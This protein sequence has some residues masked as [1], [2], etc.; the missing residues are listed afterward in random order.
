MKHGRGRLTKKNIDEPHE[1]P[2][3]GAFEND[4]L[5]GLAVVGGK[6]AMYKEG[7][8]VQLK[9]HDKPEEKMRILYL[10]CMTAYIYCLPFILFFY[11]DYFSLVLV[12]PALILW[13]VF[14]L[15]YQYAACAILEFRGYL[16]NSLSLKQLFEDIRLA[17]ESPPVC[18]F[19]I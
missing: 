16:G 19:K 13:I 17:I 4:Q 1:E 6:T 3:F 8:A 11:W 9:N 15:A 10:L 12:I 5:N 7:L 18:T 14:Y 2:I